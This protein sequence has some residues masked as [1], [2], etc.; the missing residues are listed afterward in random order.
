MNDHALIL[1]ENVIS[2]A[3]VILFWLGTEHSSFLEYDHTGPDTY[4]KSTFTKNPLISE[5]AIAVLEQS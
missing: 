5:K 3:W 1:W 4:P 2:E